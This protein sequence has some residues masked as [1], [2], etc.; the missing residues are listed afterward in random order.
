MAF[1]VHRRGAL[2]YLQADALSG[3]IHGF[4]T[5]F[6]GVSTGCLSSLNLGV[7]RGDDPENVRKNYEIVGAALGFAPADVVMTHQV[8]SAVVRR[9]DAF[10]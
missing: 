8:H 3:A 6:G 1:T 10:F 2:E 9:S 7:H 5:R 4:T